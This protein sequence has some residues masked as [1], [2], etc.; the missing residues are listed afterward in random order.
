MRLV[1]VLPGAKATIKMERFVGKVISAVRRA[2]ALGAESAR[3]ECAAAFVKAFFVKDGVK[4]IV[5]W[6]HLADEGFI[7]VYVL[8]DTR[9]KQLEPGRSEQ[10]RNLEEQVRAAVRDGDQHVIGDITG[11][12][13]SVAAECISA[14]STADKP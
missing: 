8:R 11:K 2:A 3:G 9:P 10:V 1:K 14:F 13:R 7:P 6:L 4:I 5:N 12:F